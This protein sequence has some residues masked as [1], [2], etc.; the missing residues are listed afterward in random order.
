[1]KRHPATAKAIE[2]AGGATRVAEKLG[3]TASAV[4][5]W[6]IVP[7]LRAAAL[8]RIGGGKVPLHELRPDLYEEPSK[9]A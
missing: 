2:A 4:S 9:T 5:Q 6:R 8:H 1:M 7:P 3:V